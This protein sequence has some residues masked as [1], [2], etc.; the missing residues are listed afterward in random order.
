MDNV[1]DLWKLNKFETVK[2]EKFPFVYK[3]KK[4]KS[5]WK[6]KDITWE[7]KYEIYLYANINVFILCI[8]YDKYTHTQMFPRCI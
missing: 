7:I 4:G 8:I 3:Q 6:V 1:K 5:M 2:I